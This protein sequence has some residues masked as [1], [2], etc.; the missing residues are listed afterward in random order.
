M[1]RGLPVPPARDLDLAA[2]ERAAHLALGE[3]AYSYY[4]GGAE[5]ERLLDL[6]LI[7]I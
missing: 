1:M 5:D 6:S 4:S 7:H 3:M 2:M